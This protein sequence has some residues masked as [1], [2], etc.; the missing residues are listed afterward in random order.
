MD[1]DLQHDPKYIEKMFKIYKKFNLDIVIGSRKLLSG[2]NQGLSELRRF[3]SIMLIYFFRIFKIKT[4]DPMSGFFLFKKEIYYKNK[5]FF[6]GKGFK[7]LA[8]FL[9]NSKQNLKTKDITID[10][11]RRYNSKSKMSLRVLF[12]LIQFYLLSL[13]KKI[14][15]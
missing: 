3:T 2:K 10:F 15:N 5:K 1:G 11:N 13:I 12:I 9:I 6:F 14:F 4:N 8:D 7:I